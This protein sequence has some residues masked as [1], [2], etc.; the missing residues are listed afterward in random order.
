LD[1]SS[2]SGTVGGSDG[3]GISPCTTREKKLKRN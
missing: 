3:I 2:H 1:K